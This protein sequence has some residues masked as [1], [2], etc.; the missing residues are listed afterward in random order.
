MSSEDVE[1]EI[2]N[3]ILNFKLK[4]S[5]VVP[6]IVDSELVS[7]G[8]WK[9]NVV[10]TIDSK[11]TAQKVAKSWDLLREILPI[12]RLLIPFLYSNGIYYALFQ[13]SAAQ[14]PWV[15][16]LRL[17][18]W[19]QECVELEPQS[20]CFKQTEIRRQIKKPLKNTEETLEAHGRNFPS[21]M[22]QLRGRISSYASELCMASLANRCGRV[23][24]FHKEHDFL[25]AE[26]PCEIKSLYS[27]PTIE[28]QHN[29]IA[30]MD[31]PGQVLGDKVN[32]FVE[33][34]KFVFSKKALEKMNEAYKQGGKIIFLDITHTFASFFLYMMFNNEAYDLTFCK[35]L[36]NAV[37][38]TGNK[39]KLPILATCSI[40]SYEHIMPAVI[41]P[42]PIEIFVS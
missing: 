25:L 4:D 1:S 9:I 11:A 19:Y 36:D 8:G 10:S 17:S 20:F 23:V 13:Y 18:Y 7:I 3:G 2:E 31:V 30:K 28:R 22:E 5:D 27:Y 40:T 15:D 39:D 32:P 29:K 24:S 34:W 6:N 33:F 41:I 35:A 16:L 37:N 26:L 12:D 38:I 42:M 14:P 21:S